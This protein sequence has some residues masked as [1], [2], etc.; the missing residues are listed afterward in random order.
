MVLYSAYCLIMLY[1][2]SKFQE[3]ISVYQSYLANR[4][5]SPHA[6]EKAFYQTKFHD[7]SFYG[8]KVTEHA[9]TISN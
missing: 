6:S 1:I 2:C 5:C 3:N 9:G 8:L 4:S 7:N